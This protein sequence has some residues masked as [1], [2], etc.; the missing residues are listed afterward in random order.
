MP[1][2][3]YSRQVEI[4]APRRVVMLVLLAAL[5]SCGGKD[6]ARQQTSHEKLFLDTMDGLVAEVSP[7]LVAKW[8][9]PR[10]TPN[11][12]IG[13]YAVWLPVTY[14]DDRHSRSTG[15]IGGRCTSDME[16]SHEPASYRDV[17]AEGD[18]VVGPA[19]WPRIST[20]VILKERVGASVTYEGWNIKNRRETG[21]GRKI[22]WDIFLVDVSSRQQFGYGW[23]LSDEAFPKTTVEREFTLRTKVDEAIAWVEAVRKDPSR[24]A[25]SR[26]QLTCYKSWKAGFKH[27]RK[28][29]RGKQQPERIVPG[30][31]GAPENKAMFTLESMRKLTEGAETARCNLNAIHLPGAE[32][33]RRKLGGPQ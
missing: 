7:T 32:A 15:G 14:V 11:I 24:L 26:W 31:T 3:T 19:P 10:W 30:G 4:C 5:A 8:W 13:P 6:R 18:G 25:P 1:K 33:E 21:V 16:G 29:H 17:R 27:R 20:L 22:G 12:P 23:A 28:L 9:S 2:Q